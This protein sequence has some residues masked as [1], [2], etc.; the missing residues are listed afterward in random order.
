MVF[1]ISRISIYD[2]PANVLAYSIFK[3]N[4]N[5][6]EHEKIRKWWKDRFYESLP[7]KKNKME[8]M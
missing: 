8:S 7:D 5:G 6:M 1:Q 3:G 2:P 4:W